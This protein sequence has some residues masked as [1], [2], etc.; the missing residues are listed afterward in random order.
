MNQITTQ[1]SDGLAH[2]RFSEQLGENM[3]QSFLLAGERYLSAGLRRPG[4]D[5]ALFAELFDELTV[6]A[7]DLL[8]G[9]FRRQQH[10]ALP[11]RTALLG[12]LVDLKIT[13]SLNFAVTA[14]SLPTL[15]MA[16]GAL[17]SLFPARAGE[18]PLAPPVAPLGGP[19]G[20]AM[21]GGPAASP[22]AAAAVAPAVALT[23]SAGG[24]KQRLH[25]RLESVRVEEAQD[26]YYIWYPFVGKKV[27]NQTD[28]LAF[29]IVEVDETGDVKYRSHKFGQLKEGG[30]KTFS[31]ERISS[32]NILE[33]GDRFPKSY[34]CIVTAIE[35]DD[36]GYNDFIKK[37]ADYAKKKVKELVNAPSIR[38]GAANYGVVIPPSVAN[39]IAGVVHQFTYKLID[40]L[41]SLFKNKDDVLGSHVRKATLNSYT[42]TW[43]SSNTYQSDSWEWVFSGAGGRWRTRMHWLL[44]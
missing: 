4:T 37:A 8:S 20:V 24:G 7:Q 38:S 2:D 22:A 41:S 13:D 16:R 21:G 15:R 1:E 11:Q 44:A 27:Y 5:E 10:L 30:T 6:P 25:L 23:S 43:T 26:D 36:G 35:R 42:G 17:P 32:F 40:W 12:P 39:A 28:E 18:Q 3:F 29:G 33:G 19:L 34:S 9:Y 14:R 31:D